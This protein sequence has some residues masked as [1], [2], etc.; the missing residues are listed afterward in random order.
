MRRASAAGT[1]YVMDEVV[2]DRDEALLTMGII[3]DIRENTRRLVELLEGDNGEEE[4]ED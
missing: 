4:A 1:L 3:A 2:F